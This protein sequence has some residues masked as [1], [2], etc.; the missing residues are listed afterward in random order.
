M[1]FWIAFVRPFVAL[2]VLGLICLPLRLSWV[3]LCKPHSCA[4]GCVAC[5]KPRHGLGQ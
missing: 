4:H 3:K 5:C 1:S 2:A